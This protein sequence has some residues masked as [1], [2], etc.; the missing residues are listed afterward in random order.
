MR[1][2]FELGGL[3]AALVLIGFGVA[4]IVVSADGRSEVQTALK[5]QKVVGTPDM[6]PAAISAEASK[7]GLNPA[8]LE[9][10]TCTA[11]NKAVNTGAT[12]RCFATYMR[13]HALEATSGKTYSE[14]PR[15]ATASGAGTNEAAA[16]L[17][18][19]KGAPAENPARNVWVTETALSTALNASYMGE[20]LSL[21]GIMV[22][23]AL[24]L[25]GIGF[26]VLTFAGALRNPE[27]ALGFVHRFGLRHHGGA[28]AAS[29]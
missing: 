21:F 7:A 11:A 26:A 2:F 24:L 13:I 20:Q 19:S 9:L 8:T 5:Q 29:H 1:K 17:K 28:P 18:D 6:T 14:M 10:P 4:A 22:G 16:A 23:V 15:Y 12:A 27:T 25:A 3:L